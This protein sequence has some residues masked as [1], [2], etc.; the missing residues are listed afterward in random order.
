MLAH[1]V[2]TVGFSGYYFVGVRMNDNPLHS[3]NDSQLSSVCA[4]DYYT[5]KNQVHRRH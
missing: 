3:K 1:T 2:I 5:I 4:G